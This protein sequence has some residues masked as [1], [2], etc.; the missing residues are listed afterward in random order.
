LLLV[1]DWRTR[2][3]A[4]STLHDNLAKSIKTNA[5]KSQICF[6]RLGYNQDWAN[7]AT[8]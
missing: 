8:A 5:P 6:G 3:I 7:L 4:D 2:V 1:R